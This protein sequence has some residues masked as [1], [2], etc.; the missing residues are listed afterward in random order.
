MYLQYITVIT[1]V[2]KQDN[3]D[4]DRL[5]LK[6]GYLG[7][8]AWNKTFYSPDTYDNDLERTFAVQA[9][10]IPRRHSQRGPGPPRRSTAPSNGA[11]PEKQTII[12]NQFPHKQQTEATHSIT[13]FVVIKSSEGN[14]P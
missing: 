4:P 12:M 13:F 2:S 14:S 7:Y 6:A 11:W 8:M 5:V 1:V 3:T 9:R 10:C